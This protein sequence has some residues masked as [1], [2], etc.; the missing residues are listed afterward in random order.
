MESRI[1]LHEIKTIA[2]W[3]QRLIKSQWNPHFS[4]ISSFG[5]SFWITDWKRF[6]NCRNI[7]KYIMTSEK[8]WP[9][10]VVWSRLSF[11]GSHYFLVNIQKTEIVTLKFWKRQTRFRKYVFCGYNWLD[12]HLPWEKL[13]QVWVNWFPCSF[14]ASTLHCVKEKFVPSLRPK[15]EN[16]LIFR[17]TVSAK[18]NWQNN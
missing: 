1:A 11:V 17:E 15:A 9:H 7:K 16:L 13:F 6:L 18:D 4:A 10:C 14:R 8:L 2:Q 5:M 3:G 12:L